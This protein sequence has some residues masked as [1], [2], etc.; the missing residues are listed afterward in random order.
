[1]NGIE[2]FFEAHNLLW[3]YNFLVSPLGITLGVIGF[4]AVTALIA[5]YDD[6]NVAWLCDWPLFSILY[7]CIYPI[8]TPICLLVLSLI[9]CVYI[10]AHIHGYKRRGYAV[11]KVG[12][13][14]NKKYIVTYNG[15]IITSYYP[16]VKTLH[17]TAE[18]A[19]VRMETAN[20]LGLTGNILNSI[21]NGDPELIARLNLDPDFL[22]NRMHN[23]TQTENICDDRSGLDWNSRKY[24]T[25]LLKKYHNL[26]IK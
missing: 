24:I 12:W 1:M 16:E 11:K 21:Q 10:S 17:D 7:V 15:N 5:I 2:L 3:Y 26:T 6:E 13:F 9:L 20:R 8:M 14:K 19:K 25:D 23:C 18:E 22:T 4:I